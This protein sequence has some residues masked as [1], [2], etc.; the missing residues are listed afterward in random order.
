MAVSMDALNHDMTLSTPPEAHLAMPEQDLSAQPNAKKTTNP[1]LCFIARIL[2]FGG[3]IALS[4]YAGYQ[5]YH[6]ISIAEVTRL[7]WA[8]LTLFIITFTWIALTACSAITGL[9]LPANRLKSKPS[10]IINTRT[11]LVMPVYNEDPAA[12]CA[13]L[14][15]MADSLAKRNHAKHFEIFILSDS[16]DP[17]VWIRETAAVD[18]LQQQLSGTMPVWY[19]RRYVNTDKKSGNVA[20]FVKR[21]GN[22]YDHMVVLDA[23]SLIAADT[24]ITLVREMQA[25]NDCGLIQTLPVL[26]AGKSWFARMQQFAG[27][28]YGPVI[29]NAVSAWQGNDGNYWGHNAIIRIPAFAASAGLPHLPGTRPFGGNIQS[30]DFVEAALMR[31]VGWAVRMLPGLPGS[32]EESPPTVLDAAVRDRRWAQGNIQHLAVLPTKGLRWPN[33]LHMLIGVMSYMAS[34]IWLAMMFV[35]LLISSQIASQQFDYFSDGVQLFPN[36]PVFDSQRMIALFIVTMGVLLLPKIIGLLRGFFLKPIRQSQN[37]VQLVIS[38]LVEL[39][40]S[41]LVAPIFMLLHC[42]HIWQIFRG[43]D[44]GWSEQQRNNQSVP[45]KTLLRFHWLH[46]LA[47]ISLFALLYWLQSVLLYWLMPVYLGLMISLPLSKFLSSNWASTFFCRMGVL[48]TREE[49][50]PIEEITTRNKAEAE[51]RLSIDTLTFDQLLATPERLLAHQRMTVIKPILRRGYPDM[52]LAA[53]S[54]KIEQANTL[55][56]AYSWMT[57]TELQAALSDNALLSQLSNLYHKGVRRTPVV[58]LGTCELMD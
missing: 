5:M 44:S 15:A 20:D 23:D 31:R 47:G 8:F 36:W 12:T 16:T 56:E 50:C 18:L 25:D 3:T 42:S 52:T 43:K 29:G 28:T 17:K 2:T 11:A 24:L 14:F 49:A 1:F 51:I 26:Y 30:H 58:T 6:I 19:R 21:W 48:R 39:M 7:Q 34:P 27:M 9:L 4:V 41:V 32:W 55:D 46:T 22:R 45:W 53:A 10:D 54:M 35:G 33:R 37:P 57:K 13:A 40:L 38:F